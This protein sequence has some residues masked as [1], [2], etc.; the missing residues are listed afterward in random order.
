MKNN[1]VKIWHKYFQKKRLLSIFLFFIVILID[2][3]FMCFNLYF[4]ND[5][6]AHFIPSKMSPR[7]S[8]KKCCFQEEM[9]FSNIHNKFKL[10]RKAN[11]QR[12]EVLNRNI[13]IVL[14][15]T[16]ATKLAYDTKS[17]LNIWYKNSIH[18]WFLLF[19]LRLRPQHLGDKDL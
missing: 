11:I 9:S 18:M 8:E 16:V 3:T 7:E 19:N 12:S 17:K 1:T 5:N 13:Y 14:W 15:D 10:T 6:F 4:Y 2:N